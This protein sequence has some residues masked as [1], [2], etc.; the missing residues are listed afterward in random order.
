MLTKNIADYTN[1]RIEECTDLELFEC[2]P[3]QR[4]RVQRR[5]E[6]ALL[7]FSGIPDW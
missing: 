2:R 7:H 1:K 3:D 5:E 6:E 4:K